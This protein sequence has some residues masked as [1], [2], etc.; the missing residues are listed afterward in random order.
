[1]AGEA[2]ELFTQRARLVRPGF[3]CTGDNTASVAQICR[4]LDGVPLA[5]EL[6]ATRVRALSLTEIH[7]GL[8][9][10][11]G[12]L[13]GGGRTAVA[14]QQTLRA[15][16]DWSHALLSEPERVLFQRLAVFLGG[17]DLDA[18]RAVAGDADAPRYQIV[19]ELALLVDKSLVVADNTGPTTRY[20]ML[21]TMRHYA[22][23]KLN[24]AEETDA[25]RTRHR[26]H[27]TALFDTPVSVGYRWRIKQAETEIDNL[28]AAFA[29]S[30]DHGDTG[31]AARL[32]LSLQPLWAHSR[33]LEGLAWLDAVLTDSTPVAPGARAH[34]LADK[35][36]LE[37]V[38]GVYYRIDEAEQ[39]VAIARELDDPGLLAWAL[40]ACGFTCCYSPE[41]A[42][43]YFQ[44]AIELGPALGDGWRLSQVFGA[45]AFSAYVAGNLITVRRAAEKGRDLA[46]AVGH[47]WVS[48]LCRGLLGLTQFLNADLVKAAAHGR[49]VATEAHAAHD[50]MFSAQ[51]LSLLGVTLAYQGDTT[52]ARAAAEASV[53]AATDLTAPQR[54]AS[55]G[56]LV[57]TLL[58]AGDVPAAL[59]ASEAACEACALPQLQATNGNPISRA[60]L[61]S[62]DV[63]A[64]RRWADAAV[65]AASGVHRMSLLAIHVRVAIAEGEVEQAGRDAQDALAIAAETQAYLQIP[66]VIECLAG[67]AADSGSHREAARLF[68]SAAAIRDRTGVVRYKVYDADYLA[69]VDTLGEA[70]EQNDFE[71]AWGEGAALSTA[72]AVAHARRGLDR[73]SERK[74]PPSG[75]AS[76]TPAERDVAR[77]VGEGLRNKD[78]AARLFVSTRTVQ[79]H[80]THVYTKLDVSSRVQLAHEAARHV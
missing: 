48:R 4:R 79:T 35:V 46:D 59:A 51:S 3:V 15:S 69:A 33:T 74:R 55:L 58:A 73:P 17:F 70:M 31:L 11:F 28:R 8:R 23:E 57:H 10:R 27:Y 22:L 63:T 38:A 14:R 66:D 18:A 42:L 54:G 53:E 39:A 6:A 32:A 68:G 40:A 61:A 24:E 72:D 43:P 62:G 20:R 49:E 78:I 76:L 2:V 19:D 37:A 12:L 21:E 16:V 29:W 71:A 41:I 56:A 13:T 80:L 64:A 77:L 52:G 36:I 1:L 9:D 44:E 47:G 60:A 7:D 75:W 26:D 25:V 65:S 30:R 45:Q 5:L 67:L 34:A 50:P